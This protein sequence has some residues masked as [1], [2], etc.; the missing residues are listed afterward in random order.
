VKTK[1]EQSKVNS[2]ILLFGVGFAL[3][4]FLIKII[5]YYCKVDIDV[6]HLWG[7]CLAQYGR[8]IYLTCNNITP[9]NYPSVGLL[10]S[11]G[12]LHI[13]KSITG[14]TNGEAINHAFRL[15]L[16]VF[17]GLNFFLFI[18]IARMMHFRN[19]LLIGFV[20]LLIPSNLAGGSIWGQIDNIA[21]SLCLVTSVALIKS[22]SGSHDDYEGSKWKPIAWLLLAVVSLPFFLLVKQLSI[23]SVPYFLV[24]FTVT[25]LRFWQHWQF[26][27]LLWIG[28]ALGIFAVVFY[29]LDHILA[30]PDQFLGS[31]YYYV[32]AG[33]GSYQ[34]KQISGNG[35]N[36]WIFL[37]RDM[38]SS[39]LAPFSLWSN[40]D[41]D[42]RVSPYH[43]GILLYLGW[44]LF[45]LGTAVDLVRQFLRESI[46]TLSPIHPALIAV[47]F[48]Y[49]GLSYLGFNLF[50]T[51]THERYMY[52]GYP[53]LLLAAAWF[54]TQRLV[55]SW[56]LTA[57][58]FSSAFIY[59]CFVF[60]VLGPLPGIFFAFKRHEFLA[61]LH[62]FLLLLLLDAWLQVWRTRYKIPRL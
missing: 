19:P 62:L 31:S 24:L 30:V 21:L 27:G 37:G 29:S 43:L 38:G 6:F 45:L 59:G 32:W 8:Q 47:L 56:R 3:P 46:A 4:F 35:F 49:H 14:L 34:V 57:F 28:V 2:H 52:M 41:F 9:P 39:S 23:F 60:S 12:I 25:I 1:F 33:G 5:P 16:A 48:L 42:L 7:D 10:A 22:W 36:I 15:Y 61:S 20:L 44:M 13:I 11:A 26:K 51:G 55:F 53:F 54:L 58:C 50:L 18:T 40:Q 17:D